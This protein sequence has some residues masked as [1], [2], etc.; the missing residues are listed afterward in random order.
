[1][2]F[3]YGKKYHNLDIT[4]E[5][6]NDPKILHVLLYNAEKHWAHAM[7]LKSQMTSEV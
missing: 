3:S 5:K 1:M 6:E 4:K 7:T 2:K